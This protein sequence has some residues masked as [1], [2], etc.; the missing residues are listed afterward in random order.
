MGQNLDELFDVVDE[1]DRVVGQMPRREVHRLKL[2]HRAVHLLVVNRAGQVFLHQRSQLKDQFPGYW[3]TSAAGHVGAGED[4]DST[5]ARELEEELGCRP[6]RSPQPL[7][8]VE[9]REETGQE[10]VWVYRVEAEGPFTLHP[11]EIERGGWFT[12]TEI[13][14]W[15]AERPSEIAPAL[16]YLWPR[17][18]DRLRG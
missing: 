10:F 4:Y 11:T 1:Q 8:K 17:V 18:K 13:D 15:L 16:M 9:A 3:N 7:F 2:R 14:Q 6:V 5:A 12:P